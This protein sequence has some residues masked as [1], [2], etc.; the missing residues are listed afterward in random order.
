MSVDPVLAWIEQ[1][2]VSLWIRETDSVF[3]FP[4]ILTVHA[5]GFAMVVGTSFAVDLR[6]LGWLPNVALK[7]ID[8]FVPIVWWGFALNLV[9]GV[10]LVVTYP[11]KALTNPVFWLKLLLVATGLAALVAIRR[12]VLRAIESPRTVELGRAL[13]VTSIVAWTGAMTAGRLLAYTCRRLMVDFG[14]CP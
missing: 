3:A 11:T 13:A 7:G 14:S 4:L 5:I 1:T 2:P 12:G 10:F 6:L 8:R 9:S